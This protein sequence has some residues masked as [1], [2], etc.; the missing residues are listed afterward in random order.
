MTKYIK[1][2]IKTLAF[3]TGLFFYSLVHP[4]QLKYLWLSVR[5]NN[6]NICLEQEL[7]WFTYGAI[8]WL[9]KNMPPQA[10][11][12]EW[13][14]GGS[15]LFF[16]RR[17]S[18]VVTIE[19]N[20]DWYNK[21]NQIIKNENITNGELKLMSVNQPS[22]YV[23]AIDQYGDRYFDLISVDGSERND[24]LIKAQAKLKPGGYLILDNAE[25]PDY[26]IGISSLASWWRQD[27]YG[28]G[29]YNHYFWLTTIFTKP[30]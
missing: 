23:K 21:I 30:I 4:N 2:S 29:P 8:N 18:S 12:F 9:E 15:T 10:K 6:K 24:C 17:S 14:S 1:Y 26:Q 16:A 27:F 22:N 11:I 7:P 19:N 13:G 20:P 3:F 25:R 28:P 5:Q